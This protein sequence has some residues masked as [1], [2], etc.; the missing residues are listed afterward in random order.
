[1]PSR[2]TPRIRSKKL[3][4]AYGSFSL[5]LVERGVLARNPEGGRRTSYAL[6]KIS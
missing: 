4:G 2:N 6:A 5:P 3:S 1:M